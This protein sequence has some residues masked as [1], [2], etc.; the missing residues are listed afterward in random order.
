[1]TGHTATV[2]QP[3]YNR[4]MHWL[5]RDFRTGAR[6]SVRLGAVLCVL[7]V[8]AFAA[9]EFVK[10]DAKPAKSY[11]EHDDHTDEKV[12]VGIDAYDTPEKA[13]IFSVKWADEGYLPVFVVITND[14]DQPVSLAS[15]QVQ[16]ITAHRDKI[17]PATND[18]LYRRLSHIKQGR[19][20]PLP[21]PQKAKGSIGKKTLDEIDRAQFDAKAVEPHATQSGFMFFD[22]SGISSAVPGARVYLTGLRDAKGGELLYF[23]IPLQR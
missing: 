23:E 11:P 18:D 14:S 19:V 16:F 4:N 12:A 8:L 6:S 22:I 7:C 9:K 15:M 5:L 3:G 17:S 2:A 13:Q 1:M 10:P 21:I 20:Y